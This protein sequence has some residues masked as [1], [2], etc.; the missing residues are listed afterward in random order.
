MRVRFTRDF[1]WDPP[2]HNGRTTIAYKEGA[3][4]RVRK[5]C[6]EAAVAAGAA[7]E[8]SDGGGEAERTTRV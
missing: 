3:A 1:D 5:A 4:G 2:E 8:L 7:V 6:G